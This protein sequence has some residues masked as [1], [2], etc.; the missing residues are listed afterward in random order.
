MAGVESSNEN[1]QNAQRSIPTVF[2]ANLLSSVEKLKGRDNYANWSF[3]IGNYFEMCGLQD[4]ISGVETNEQKLSLAKTILVFSID[5]VNHVHVRDA[6]T[7][8]KAWDNLR[9]IYEDNGI[10]RKIGLIRALVTT[11]L[12][13]CSSVEEYVNKIIGTAHKLANIGCKLEEDWI[14]TFL[15]AGLPERYNTMIMGIE[16]SGIRITGD[17]I[18]QKLLQDIG[19]VQ[20]GESAFFGGQKY[21]KGDRKPRG[22][23]CF[24]CN[25]H[26]HCANDCAKKKSNG[27]KWA[28]KKKSGAFGVV[29]ASGSFG[30]DEWYLDSGASQHLTLHEHWLR[31]KCES[32]VTEITVA[33]DTQLKVKCKGTLTIH[34]V[35]DGRE[36]DI[37]VRV[38]LCVPGLAT[39][40]LSVSQITRNGN[41]VRF[42]T[43]GCSIYNRKRKL[44]ATA[45]LVN[46]VYR[47]NDK[48]SV[49]G[50]MSAESADINIWHRRLGH[51]NKSDLLKMKNGIVSCINFVQSELSACVPCLE[52]K[53]TRSSFNS[54]G[55]RATDILKLVH[56][57]I[58]G[59]MET[60]SIGGARYF[61]LFID[62]FSRKTFVYF[63]K[64]KSE[65]STVFAQFKTMV[66]K[67]TGCHIK[68]L[69]S[70]NE[71]EYCGSEFQNILRANGIVHQT[72]N[73]YTPE[74]NGVAERKNRS[75]VE[76]AKCML[77]DA[78]L[79]IEFWADAV[80]TAVYIMNRST[81]SALKKTTPQEAFGDR[82]PDVMYAC[83]YQNRS[84]RSG[85]RGASK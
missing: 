54:V 24:N 33:N 83:M 6:D 52:G 61:L 29:I 26:G 7:V 75:V 47:L 78:G 81:T 48:K 69:R 85:H 4:C 12:E 27:E 3:A 73:F 59:P 11:Q 19:N 55:T 23:R 8:K 14:G 63:L 10:T 56:T 5:P 25:E 32:D 84:E 13:N 44:L 60:A 41:T 66:E 16:S 50:L 30:K 68:I 15:L 74:Q 64:Q 43:D 38:V 65:V 77:F 40:L 20:S 35:E 28:V 2:N 58:C 31:D 49:F 36:V 9:S 80:H 1:A 71:T 72:S 45:T 51:M 37:T 22:M 70:D 21:K 76:K 57:D 46:N 42:K 39:N 18:K 82:K 17:S 62:D 67:Q 53:Q 79:P 34:T